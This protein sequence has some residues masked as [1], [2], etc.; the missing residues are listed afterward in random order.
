M[1][2]SD[3]VFGEIWQEQGGRLPHRSSVDPLCNDRCEARFLETVGGCTDDPETA[4]MFAQLSSELQ[5]ICVE[6]CR[7]RLL[8]EIEHT[9]EPADAGV[10]GG[11][12]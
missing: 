5:M 4:G 9:P 3:Q 7:T 1:L 11:V 12:Y 2:G 6:S 10:P 8:F